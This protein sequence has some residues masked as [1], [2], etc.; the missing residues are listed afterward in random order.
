MALRRSRVDPTLWP[1]LWANSEHLRD[2]GTMFRRNQSVDD[3]VA[4]SLL[5]ASTRY[6]IRLQWRV[7]VI[8][9][10][11]PA[12]AEILAPAPLQVTAELRV[13]LQT[14]NPL[15]IDALKLLRWKCAQVIHRLVGDIDR[16]SGHASTPADAVS[17]AARDQ[18]ASYRVP[19]APSAGGV[20]SNSPGSKP[21]SLTASS[22]VRPETLS[23]PS[24]RSAYSASIERLSRSS[25]K[26]R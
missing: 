18:D 19:A 12:S 20:P 13:G 2:L 23:R 25:I 26:S 16:N 6:K 15:Q 22:R 24:T 17:A 14:R 9:I 4:R 5:G 10:D 21:S 1:V 11:L 3:P 8:E 7:V